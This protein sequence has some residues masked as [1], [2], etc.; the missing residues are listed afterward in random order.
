MGEKLV[1]FIGQET[2]LREGAHKA[3]EDLRTD[4]F[5]AAQGALAKDPSALIFADS[6]TKVEIASIRTPG[7]ITV[8]FDPKIPRLKIAGCQ[9]PLVINFKATGKDLPR[10][11]RMGVPVSVSDFV[12]LITQTALSQP[13]K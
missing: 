13:A 4:L 2:E 7:C 6:E 12:R 1:W 8:S 9:R 10:L 3:W 5:V 11:E